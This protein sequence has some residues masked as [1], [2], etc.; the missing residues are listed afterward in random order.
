MPF[1]GILMLMSGDFRQTLPAI[2]R[3]EPAEV[4]SASR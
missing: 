1:G 4:I 2:P 3:A